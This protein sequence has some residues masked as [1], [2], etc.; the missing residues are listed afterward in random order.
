ML[1]TVDLA[2]FAGGTALLGTAAVAFHRAALRRLGERA[3]T[4]LLAE[5]TAGQ[6]LCFSTIEALAYAIEA[7]D[8]FSQ[9]HLACVGRVTEALARLF[10]LPEAEASSLRAAAL[11]HH[12]G[13]LGVPEHILLKPESLTS[14][15]L[16]R[17]RVHPVLGARILASV[18]FPWEVVPIVRHHAE[19][20]DGKG[21]PDG[22]AGSAIPFGSRILSV[23]NAYSALLQP[24]PYRSA[25]SPPDAL[26]EIEG[27]SGTQ[28]DPA[29]VAAFRTVAAELRAEEEACPSRQNL[30]LAPEARAALLDIAAAQQET[31]NLYQFSQTVNSSLHL[32]AVCDNLM[33]CVRDVIP[34]CSACAVF[35]PDDDGEFL[36]AC[37]AQGINERHLL[38]SS[39][40]VG[41][42]LTGRAFS[43]NEQIFASFVEDDIMCRNVSDLW[44]PFRSTLILPLSAEGNCI[45]TLNL[46]ATQPDAFPA[47]THR[48]LRLIATQAAHAV[49][50]ARRF[51]AAQETAY[52]DPMTGLK[53]ARYLHEYLEKELNRAR[54]EHAPLAVLNIDLDNFKPINDQFGHARGDQTLREVAAILQAHVR[55]YDLAA[56]YAGDEF[57]VV[58]AQADRDIAEQ[59]SRKLKAAIERHG[60]R[61]IA[62]DP[63]FPAIGISVGIAVFP[64][65]GIDRESLLCRSDA[66]MYLDKRRKK[67][68]TGDREQGTVTIPH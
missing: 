11:L 35:V 32:E 67:Q 17:L 36:R 48:I 4:V 14:D 33:A 63:N 44:T 19:H 64:E 39:T 26:A 66:A 49:D 55:N 7:S 12:V 13:R 8:R 31:Q 37:A 50:N 52:T 47:S 61:L 20:W 68:E 2:A 1:F 46:Y 38:G 29:V 42:Y 59:A 21:Y 65:D 40:R 9:G 54:R 58:L 27:R 16:E 57:V 5:R 45:G 43:R 18:P 53:N 15:E 62:R 28:F 6:H 51:E 60:Q 30:A 3:E 10:A 41:T 25:F 34:A 24:R 23:A 56:R 22:L